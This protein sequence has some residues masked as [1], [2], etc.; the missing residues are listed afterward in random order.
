[1][2]AAVQRF[3]G[4]KVLVTGGARGIGAGVARRFAAEGATVGIID[5]LVEPGTAV[6]A[7][8]G[9]TFTAVDLTDADAARAAVESSIASIG[10]VEVLVCSAGILHLGQLLETSIATWDAVHAINTRG[11][12]IAM[13]VAAAAMI[14]AG[15]GGSIVNV[16]S[17]AAKKGGGGE[18]AYAASKSAVVGLTRAAAHEWG[19]HGITVNA[20]CP[21]YVLTEMGAAT[22]TEAD[23]AL[24]SS[25]SP[26]GRLGSAEDVA[27]VV[28]FLASPDGAYLTGQAVN[29][30]GGMAMH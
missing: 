22:R 21:G 13:Q 24:W 26:L 3:S 16:A 27:G 28:T 10:G 11:T 2:E 14:A 29:I 17:M 23:V 6:A 19:K 7:E 12:F 18:G 8:I 9:G 25:Y 1:M 5:L 15:S 4:T 30:T 20:V